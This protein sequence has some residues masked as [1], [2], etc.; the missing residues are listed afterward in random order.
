LEGVQSSLSYRA[1][2]VE[3][4]VTEIENESETNQS[5][6]KAAMASIREIINQR[7]EDLLREIVENAEADRGSVEQYKRELQAEHQGLIEQVL[8]FV[9][10]SRDKEPKKLIEAK[11]SFDA[12]RRRAD[13]RLITL[14]P[15]SRIKKHVVGLEKLTAMATDIRNLKVGTKPKYDNPTLRQKIANGK[16]QATLDLSSATLTDQDMELVASEL[17]INK[18]SD[19][20]NYLV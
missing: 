8:N 1:N 7:E 13:E 4:M 14:K 20:H 19:S 9:T 5:E 12:Y 16:N 10:I 11:P 2:R 3:N 6:V 15:L 18:V 17:E